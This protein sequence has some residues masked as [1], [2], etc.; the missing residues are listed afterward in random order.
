MICSE[1]ERAGFQVYKIFLFGSRAQGR[2]RPNSDWD[3][4][5]ILNKDMDRKLRRQIASRIAWK[6]A[7]EG[8][9]IDIFL[10]SNRVVQERCNDKGYLIYYVLKEG[11]PI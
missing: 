5:V 8:I 1:V 9:F 7:Q 6:L 11:I 2:S 4:Y 3:F 10:Q